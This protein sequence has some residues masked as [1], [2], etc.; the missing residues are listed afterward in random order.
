H[1]PL[2]LNKYLRAFVLDRVARTSAQ[3]HRRPL[4]PPVPEALDLAPPPATR[5]QA[6]RDHARARA[7][8]SRH[9]QSPQESRHDSWR[10][11]P[12]RSPSLP[13]L[14]L[15]RPPDFH[16][17][18]FRSDAEKHATHKVAPAAASAK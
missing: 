15:E 12:A 17:A 5:A 4:L 10:R 16:P 7:Y 13:T 11:R 18:P 2:L 14:N 3:P 1:S 9:S 6:L 8:R